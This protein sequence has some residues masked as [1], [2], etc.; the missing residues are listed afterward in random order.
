MDLPYKPQVVRCILTK[1]VPTI[2]PLYADDLHDLIVKRNQK[3]IP[4]ITE[5]IQKNPTFIAVGA[6]HLPG[7]DGVLNLLKEAGY[8]ITPID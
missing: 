5:L 1:D 6:A 7:N 3:W 4:I 2:G 8:T